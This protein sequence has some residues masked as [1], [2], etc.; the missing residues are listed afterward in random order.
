MT[1]DP[2]QEHEDWTTAGGRDRLHIVRLPPLTAAEADTLMGRIIHRRLHPAR[3]PPD[4]AQLET[5]VKA[6]SSTLK[7]ARLAVGTRARWLDQLFVKSGFIPLSDAELPDKGQAV[8]PAYLPL[9]P[10]ELRDASLRVDPVIW[11]HFLALATERRGALNAL[12][13]VPTNFGLQPRK[14]PPF[15]EEDLLAQ[16]VLATDAALRYMLDVTAAYAPAGPAVVT[17]ADVRERF[18]RKHEED[19]RALCAAHVL[20]F[21]HKRKALEM[22]SALMRRVVEAKLANPLHVHHVELLR[23]LQE[24]QAASAAEAKLG[25]NTVLL[26]RYMTFFG[27]GKL[28]TLR[29]Q[30]EK[31]ESEIAALRGKLEAIVAKR[32]RA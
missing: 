4:A 1:S 17:Y 16:R 9:L 27:F 28:A 25:G 5:V 7:F 22:E 30:V 19:L 2:K 24:W 3:P 14:P 29:A 15:S 18:F 12:L 10:A 31:L 32:D 11:E 13:E 6:Y 20:Y 26:Q 21:D 8:D 23:K